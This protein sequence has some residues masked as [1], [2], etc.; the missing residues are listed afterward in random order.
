LA[1]A[2]L[3][4]GWAAACGGTSSPAGA[5]RSASGP[6]PN[7][8]VII[9]DDMAAGLFG[10][11]R[12]FP[13]LSLP[14]LE[15][16]AAQGVQFEQAFVTTSLCSPSRASIL[17]GVY[18]H[19]HGVLVNDSM[20][21]PSSVATCPRLLQQAG[22][23]TALIG[24]WHMDS[25]RDAPRPGFDYWLSFR[26]QGTYNDPVLNLNGTTVQT[27]GYMTSILTDYAVDWLRQRGTEPF[28]LILSHKAAHGP[29]EPAERHRAALADA[30]LPEP[31]S[32]RDSFR[33]KPA[34]QRRYA[35]CGGTSLAFSQCP[36]P[37]PSELPAWSWSPREPWRLDYL[38]TLLALDDSVGS[39]VAELERQG[40]ARS[41]YVLFMSDNGM[42]LGEHRLGDKRLAYEESMR[43]PFV[44]AGAGL[45]PRRVNGMALNLDVAPTLLELAG[46]PVPREMH[47]RSLVRLLR[48][49]SQRV[50][51]SFVYEYFTER[52]LPVVPPFHGIRTAGMKYLRYANAEE[53]LY[54]LGADPFELANL[55]ARPEWASVKLDLRAQLDR[56][57]DETSP[58]E[59]TAVR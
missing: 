4:A 51:D 48:G 12:R 15:R 10:A 59:P 24:K 1:V 16:L 11:G 7:F 19:T 21:L 17:S 28:L 43:I 23:R 8:V 49:E 35:S 32:F 56:L 18:A 45:P 20:D 25:R 58:P 38:R 50:R 53:E 22:Y 27:P 36:D 29:F 42:L 39:V 33:E 34:W 37:L 31:P 2:L 57:L 41:T 44:M 55:S 30:A 5:T 52:S 47:G 14:N 40:L 46:V 6:R 54:D 3:L 13:F 9:A 26:G